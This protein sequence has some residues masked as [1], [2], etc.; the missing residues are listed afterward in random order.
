MWLSTCDTSKPHT[1]ARS[2]WARHSLRTSSRS[3]WSQT[4]CTVRGKPPSP[5]RRLGECVIGPQ[6]YVSHSEFIVRC[7][8]TSSP[9]YIA[10]ASRAHGHG[11]ISVALVATPSRSASYTATFA[12][13][14]EPRSS[15][16]RISSLA[17]GAYPR[18]SASDVTA[19]R[20]REVRRQQFAGAGD[21]LGV[22]ERHV[23]DQTIDA[24]L[25]QGLDVAHNLV[26]LSTREAFV[27]LVACHTR[28]E[29][30]DT[31]GFIGIGSEHQRSQ[32]ARRDL[33]RVATDL[34]AVFA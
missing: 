13:R 7:T 31:R 12:E 23:E 8:P 9:R 1:M 30:P 20:L 25:E 34:A 28:E 10:A 16:L 27:E 22:G 17:S 5:S 19:L 6:R 18:R 2:T 32:A 24:R 3:A 33:G 14:V 29:R 4:S 15:Q 26:G 11:T 21:R